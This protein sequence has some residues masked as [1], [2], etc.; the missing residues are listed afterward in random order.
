MDFLDKSLVLDEDTGSLAPSYQIFR[1][2]NKLKDKI[3][4]IQIATHLAKIVQEPDNNK[5]KNEVY[6]PPDCLKDMLSKIKVENR[7]KRGSYTVEEDK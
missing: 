6:K 4:A 1:K 7:D 3:K 2:T 5:K